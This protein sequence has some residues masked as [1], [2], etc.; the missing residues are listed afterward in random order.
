M[1][2]KFNCPYCNALIAFPDKHAGK[3]AR[4]QTCQQLFFIPSK[5]D[6]KPKKFITKEIEIAEP[7]PGFYRAVFIDN[8]KIFID[9]KNVTSLAFIVAVICF[10]FFLARA[11]CCVNYI[12]FAVVWGWLLGF[13]LNVIYETAF[14]I[15]TLPQIYFGEGIAFFLNIIKPFLIFFCT[16]AVAQAPFII[17]YMLLKDKGI[18]METL[19]QAEIGLRLLLQVLF[20]LGLFLFPM[21]ILTTA[22][23]KDLTMLR[24]D[25]IVLAILRAFGPYLV[26][27]A[28]LAIACIMQMQ[29]SQYE[30]QI[31]LVTNAGRLTL[32]LTVQVIA[33]IAMRAIGLFYRH[34]SCHLP[35]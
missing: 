20:I 9:S 22:V 4:C 31:P 12:T 26:I 21:A 16:M 17:A 6:E 1:T 5:D 34:Y 13:Y 19:W 24:P 27:V 11:I 2:I 30:A 23:G 29:T 28:L 10:N 33:I 14:E 15:D 7:V 18:T 32:N 3:R 25:Y 8:W 35:W